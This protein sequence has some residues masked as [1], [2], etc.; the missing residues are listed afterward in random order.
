MAR[1]PRPIKPGGERET[2]HLPDTKPDCEEKP[3]GEE[4]GDD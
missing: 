1:R 2:L 3:E 4:K